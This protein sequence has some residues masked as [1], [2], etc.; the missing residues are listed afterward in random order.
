M[1]LQDAIE[2]T[3][4]GLWLNITGFFNSIIP[5]WVYAIFS[6]PFSS[7]LMLAVGF[8][9]GYILGRWGLVTLITFGG[10][11]LAAYIFGKKK[12]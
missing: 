7:W 3:F 1:M 4:G 5:E 2:N 8:A 6:I 10:V 9:V 11:V 12:K